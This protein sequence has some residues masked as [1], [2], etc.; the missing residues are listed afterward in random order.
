MNSEISF[1]LTVP[2]YLRGLAD[3]EA[4]GGDDEDSYKGFWPVT[5]VVVV[6]FIAG[7]AWY[8]FCG[9]DFMNGQGNSDEEY[10]NAVIR[11]R[12]REEERRKECPEK[13]KRKILQSFRRCRTTM[14]V[15]SEDLTDDQQHVILRG[16]SA[17]EDGAEHSTDVLRQVQNCCAVCLSEYE[18]GD[19]IVWSRYAKRLFVRDIHHS[20]QNFH[21]HSLLCSNTQCTHVFHQDCLMDWFL[22][23]TEEAPACP[24]CRQDFT[25]LKAYAIEK[26]IRWAP[27]HSFN[28]SNIRFR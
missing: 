18:P 26:R 3:A 1:Q 11:R 17:A 13:R 15:T 20:E 5:I 4:S 21:S 22:R 6:V 14:T 2:R 7:C 27:G 10:R 25:D 9:H 12:Q 8:F 28:P 19:Q 24:I 16:Q 23:K